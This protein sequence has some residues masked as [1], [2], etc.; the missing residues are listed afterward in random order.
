MTPAAVALKLTGAQGN[1]LHALWRARKR[2][3]ETPVLVFGD[4]DTIPIDPT[5]RASTESSWVNECNITVNRLA[6]DAL[7]RL[8][9]ATDCYDAEGDRMVLYFEITP[10]G[11]DVHTQ[12]EFDEVAHS[13]NQA[14]R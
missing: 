7:V 9:L 4:G 8:T 11:V 6:A 13:K 5:A 10:L 2:A 14:V 1:A 3:I 12:L